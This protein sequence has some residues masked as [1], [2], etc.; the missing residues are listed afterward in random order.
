MIVTMSRQDLQGVVD[1]AKNK[2]I[3][4]L[5]TKYDVQAACERAANMV[6]ED[7]QDIRK[8]NLPYIKQNIALTEQVWR[9]TQNIDAR[10][11]ALEQNLRY[12]VAAMNRLV[13][14]QSRTVNS[15]QRY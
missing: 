13:G 3:E 12:T 11:N 5:V 2:I 6:I 9:R 8:A 15:L 14:Q 10:L 1:Y 7:L 4:R